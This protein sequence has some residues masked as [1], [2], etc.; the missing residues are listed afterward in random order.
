M[1]IKK[2]REGFEEYS[3]AFDDHLKDWIAGDLTP[4][5]LAAAIIERAARLRSSRR[6]IWSPQVKSEFPQLLAAIFVLYAILKSGDAYERMDD[7][8]TRRSIRDVDSV[9]S[10]NLQAQVGG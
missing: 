6:G 10:A 3:V 2:L 7:A 1:P 5:Q 4:D 8:A 9:E